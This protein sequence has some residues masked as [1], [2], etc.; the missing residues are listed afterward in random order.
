MIIVQCQRR[1]KAAL[2]GGGSMAAAILVS[3]GMLGASAVAQ[4]EEN[5]DETRSG[6]DTITVTAQFREQNLQD[7]PLSITAVTG[8]MMEARSQISIVDIAAQAPNVRLTPGSA[9]FG[10]SLQAHIRGVGQ[11]DFNFALEP[12]VGMYVDDVYYSTLTGSVVDLLDL[13]RVEILRG[14]QGTLAGQNSIGG[15]VKLYSRKPDGEGGGY[16]QLTYGSYDRTEV[17]A[18]GEFTVVPDQ[19]FARI[20]G[21]AHSRD[22]YV[23]RYDYACTHPGTAV[24]S[25]TTSGKCKLGTEGGKSYVAGRLALRWLP[26]ERVEVNVSGDYTADNSE[27][28]PFT[29]LYVGSPAG[30]GATPAANTM[31]NGVP[32]GTAAGSPF[33]SYSLFGDEWADDTFSSSPY[34]NYSTYTDP[35]PVDGTAPFSVPAI[36]QVDSWGGSAVVDVELAENLAFKSVTAYRGYEGGWG[37]DEDGTPIGSTTLSNEVSHLQFTQE[38]RL[39]GA[40]LDDRVNFTVGGFYLKAASDYDGRIGLRTL[41]FVEADDIDNKTKAAFFNA[42]IQLTDALNIGGG[43]RYTDIEKMFEYG[44]KGIPGNIF[45]G[46]AH[47]AVRPLDG[48]VASF[49]GDHLDYRAVVQYRWAPELMTYAQISTGFRSGGINPRPFFPAQALPH[50]PETLT[51]YEIGAKTDLFDNRVRFN[52]SVFL[53]KYNDILFATTNC[54]LPGAPPAP[55]FLPINAGEADVKGFELEFDAEPAE[56][57]SFDASLSYLDFKYKS[58]DPLAASAGITLSNTAPFAPE[59]MYSIGA[60]YEFRAGDFGT[61]TPRVDVSYQDSYYTTPGNSPFSLVPEYTLVNARVTWRDPEENWSVAFEVTN[62]TDKLYY[63]GLF[64]NRGSSQTVQGLP[65]APRQWALTVKRAF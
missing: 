53:N 42:D 9:P 23:T 64:D 28:S 43:V 29:L 18:A 48:V 46:L 6:I 44:R 39:S 31:I 49:A 54:P 38:A 62:L 13:D 33:I 12:G 36:Y 56:G 17:R 32:L 45:G 2:R 50:N 15:A 3:A 21:V 52:A 5:A 40:F 47:P 19:L 8:E 16:A 55:C 10:P 30:P 60:Q 35:S 65:A 25:F 58:I 63:L 59:W 26:T 22:G 37:I 34:I 24:P 11:H 41:Q 7:T 4:D 27:A 57:L 20:A 61:L 14:P 1:L 51:A